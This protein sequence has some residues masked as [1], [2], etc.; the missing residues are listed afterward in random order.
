MTGEADRGLEAVKWIAFALMLCDHVGAFLLNYEY[1]AL[2]LLGRLVFP[3]FALALAAGLRNVGE[4]V[5]WDVCKRLLMWAVITQIPYSALQQG[6]SLNVMFTLWFGAF[7]YGTIRY[8][9]IGWIRGFLVF[10]GSVGMALMEYGPVGVGLVALCCLGA[11]AESRL[12]RY[13]FW[14]PLTLLQA[15]NGVPVAML[16]PGLFWLI[17]RYLEVPRVRHAFYWL[18]PAQWVLLAAA[19][20]L[21]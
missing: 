20:V 11:C 15:V 13:A 17:R 2:Y 6:G 21:R 9:R 18:Y 10:A 16:A 8:R 3:L 1:P 7:V 12:G 5:H 4:L 19:R 14:V